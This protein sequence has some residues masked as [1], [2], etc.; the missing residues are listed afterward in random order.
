MDTN[1]ELRGFAN[2]SRPF[3]T[4]A[5]KSETVNIASLSVRLPADKSPTI[6]ASTDACGPILALQEYE[7]PVAAGAP[8][9]P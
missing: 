2:D 4:G 9:R 3:V 6:T 8:G 7:L 5:Q 1:V